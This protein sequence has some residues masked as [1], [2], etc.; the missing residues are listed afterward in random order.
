MHRPMCKFCNR[1]PMIKHIILLI[2]GLGSIFQNV[3]I[4]INFQNFEIEID[5]LKLRDWDRDRFFKIGHE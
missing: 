1:G 5:F 2:F 4:G 3:G